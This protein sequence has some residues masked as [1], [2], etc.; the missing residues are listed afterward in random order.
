MTDIAPAIGVQTVWN[1]GDETTY[2]VAAT[3]DRSYEITPTESMERHNRIAVR[4]GMR[5]GAFASYPGTRRIQTGHDATGGVT[6]EVIPSGFGRIFKQLLGGTPT[7]TQQGGTAAYRHVYG[8]GSTV[9]KSLS[10]QKVLRDPDLNVIQTVTDLGCKFVSGEFTIAKDALLRLALT[11]DAREE[12]T[13]VAAAAAAYPSASLDPFHFKQAVLSV[14]GT[15]VAQANEASVR[16]ERTLGVDR[17]HLGNAG[18]KSEQIDVGRPKMS[19]RLAVDFISDDLYA[20]YV[21][22]G[23][24]DLIM[25]FVG[26][27][28]A[29]AYDYALTITVP[30]IHLTGET[31][32]V[33][34]AGLLSVAAP[35]ESDRALGFSVVYV[36]TDTAA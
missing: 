17:R 20:Y 16:I 11:V 34:D 28:I 24:G 21:E 30:D 27:N 12:V 6:L 8:M 36:T 3:L 33:G 23:G 14:A 31:P 18:L 25:S 5:G 10:L 7:I 22:D 13:D 9:G 35:W 1:T 19:G 26:E 32:K 4:E 15:E 2:G 29:G